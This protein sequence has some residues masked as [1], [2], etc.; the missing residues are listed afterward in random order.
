MNRLTKMQ[1]LQNTCAQEPVAAR[2]SLPLCRSYTGFQS[3]TEYNIR[4]CCTPSVLSTTKHLSGL[5]S[6]YRPTSSLR[7]ESTASLTV[8]RTQTATYG[9]HTFTKAAAN[10]WNSLPAHIRNSDSCASFQHQLKTFLFR[11]TILFNIII[12]LF[13]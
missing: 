3:T 5:L 9:D 2:T 8:P 13:I 11:Q 1:R 4:S 12:I 7:S 10:L 6:I